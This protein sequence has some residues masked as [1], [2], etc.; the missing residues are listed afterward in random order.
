MTEIQDPGA[1]RTDLLAWNAARNTIRD[2]IDHHFETPG[3][4]ESIAEAVMDAHTVT[5]ERDVNEHGVAVRRYVLRGE[6]EVDPEVAT[7][8]P[9]AR[10]Q[11]WR[12]I[13]DR[14]AGA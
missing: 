5:W 12:Q 7:G 6:W 9:L 1:P 13:L 4:A 2:E 10:E 11:H 3:T 8:K 14:G